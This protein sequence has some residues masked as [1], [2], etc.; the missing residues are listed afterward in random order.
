MQVLCHR[1]FFLEKIKGNTIP[2]LSTIVK[3]LYQIHTPKA[4]N[5]RRF[6]IS[7]NQ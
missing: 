7:A 4:D 1:R 5:Q 2:D 3:K 6:E